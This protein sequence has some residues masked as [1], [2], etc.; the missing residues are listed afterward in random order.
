MTTKKG[1]RPTAHQR[2]ERKEAQLQADRWIAQEQKRAHRFQIDQNGTLYLL[3]T[4]VGLSFLATAALTADGTI[5]SAAYAQLQFGWMSVLYFAALEIA[6]LAFLILYLVIGSREAERPAL[7]FKLLVADTILIVGTNVFHVLDAYGFDWD[8]PELW[9]GVVLRSVVPVFF[10]LLGH[11]LSEAVF[12]KA[13][14][15]A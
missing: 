4:L 6:A 7:W 12:A 10:V 11:G 15:R 9:A 13:V 3:V 8:S 2:A 5:A 1:G 14:K